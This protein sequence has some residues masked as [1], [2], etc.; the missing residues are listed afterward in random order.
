MTDLEKATIIVNQLGG[1]KFLAMTGCKN[2]L[3]LEN[4]VRMNLQKNISGANL[5]EV[6]LEPL[7]IYNEIL[8]V[9]A[10]SFE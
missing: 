6:T 7:D 1:K 8:Q 10:R 4:G 2:I 9:H 5:L 3:A